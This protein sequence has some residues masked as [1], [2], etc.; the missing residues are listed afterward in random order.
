VLKEL[1]L[2]NRSYRRFYQSETMSSAVLEDLIDAGRYTA[3]AANKQP[4]RYLLCNDGLK[5]EEIFQ[6][7]KWAGYLTEWDGPAEGEKPAAYI[8][9]VSENS[10]FCN[11][12]TGIA[13]QTIL[14]RAVEL[15]YGGCMIASVDR[16]KIRE[17]YNLDSKYEILLVLA[18]GKP[19]EEV[20]LIEINRDDDIRYWRDEES[21]HFV[22]KRKLSDI[23]IGKFGG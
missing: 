14:L 13:A 1:I 11:Y 18:L 17:L 5:N 12:D 20:N 6:C 9:I 16:D 23:I 22:P 3:S 2:K 8:I 7:L 15:G 19:N 10:N 4:L 21:R